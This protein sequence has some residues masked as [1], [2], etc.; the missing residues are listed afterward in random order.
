MNLISCQG[1]GVV[2]D[3]E[4]LSLHDEADLWNDDGSVNSD[5]AE[6]DDA[7]EEFRPFVHCPCCRE[8]IVC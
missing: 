4:A 1:C 2:L 3:K 8:K 7:R 6:W 5:R